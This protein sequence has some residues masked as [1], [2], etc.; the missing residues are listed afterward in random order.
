MPFAHGLFGC[1]SNMTTCL[2]GYCCPCV[3]F[4]HTAAKAGQTDCLKG[5]L[6][7][8]VPCL[9][10]Y[11]LCQNRKMIRESNGEDVSILSRLSSW[12]TAVG[13]E[14]LLR[15]VLA[16]IASQCTAA[17]AVPSFNKP[18]LSKLSIA[19]AALSKSQE[20]KILL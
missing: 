5:C 17:V 14:K 7:M 4:G 6:S 13:T 3:L 16:L 15:A 20:N 19:L 18:I 11:C 12:V 9:N 10:L 1:F 2:L 8:F